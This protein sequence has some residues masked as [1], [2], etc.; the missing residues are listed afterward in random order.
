M[1]LSRSF[2][3]RALLIALLPLVLSAACDKLPRN[4]ALDGQW[5]LVRR[6]NADVTAQRIYWAVQLDLIQLRSPRVAPTTSVAYSCVEPIHFWLRRGSSWIA[7]TVATC[8]SA[9]ATPPIFRLSVST[10]CP[11]I[12]PF[13]TSPPPAWC[14]PA[15]IKHWSFA[16][17]EP[18]GH[19]LARA[20]VGFCFSSS[21]SPYK[22]IVISTLRVKIS[23]FGPTGMRLSTH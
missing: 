16:N 2:P 3:L 23:L 17:G 19:F 18:L 11:H 21:P 10:R 20:S 15:A 14:S 9:L 6:N 5:Q 8:T 13:A 1:I 7:T 4:G 22:S 12:S